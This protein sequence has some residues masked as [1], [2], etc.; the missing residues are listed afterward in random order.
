M[1]QGDLSAIADPSER[2]GPEM[3]EWNKAADAAVAWIGTPYV[4]QASC[5]GAGTDCLGLIRGV[6][7]EVVGAEPVVPPPYTSDWA[8]HDGQEA[9]LLAASTHLRPMSLNE[10]ARGT[11]LL[12][13][14]R[15]GMVAKHL[16]I[17]THV[18][19]A[20]KFVHAYSGHGVVESSLSRPWER[21][22]V[23]IFS[24][25]EGVN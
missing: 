20:P 23:G 3:N 25:P 6:W 7:R 14:L 21:R 19:V 4:H 9:L 2:L 15:T 12:F 17:V 18:G 1:E 22:I 8:E 5:K 10:M 13:R 11:V 24:F 16:G